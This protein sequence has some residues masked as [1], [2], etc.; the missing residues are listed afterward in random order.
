ML[1][2]EVWYADADENAI[3]SKIE[4]FFTHFYFTV[5]SIFV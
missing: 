1:A 3:N 2:F 5:D 4:M